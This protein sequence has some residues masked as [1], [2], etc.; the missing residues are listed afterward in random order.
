[1]RNIFSGIKKNLK[2]TVPSNPRPRKL[3]HIYYLTYLAE[4]HTYTR[5]VEHIRG[6]RRSRIKRD[7]FPI[8]RILFDFKKHMHEE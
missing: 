2:N 7:S 6:I 1:M 3:H 4:S 5:F 8:G